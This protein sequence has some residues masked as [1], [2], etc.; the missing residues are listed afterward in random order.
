MKRMARVLAMLVL[1]AVA[2]AAS[3]SAA[4]LEDFNDYMNEDGTYSYYFMQGV[5]VTLSEEWYQN[6]FVK[7]DVSS[8]TFYHRD[9]YDKYAAEGMEDGGKLFTIGCSVNTSFKDLD[10][11]TYIGFDEEEMLNYYAVK[12]TDYTAY[13]SDAAT[14]AEYDALWAGVDEVIAGITLA[15]APKGSADEAGEVSIDRIPSSELYTIAGNELFSFEI[16]AGWKAWYN[17]ENT[18]LVEKESDE[19]AFIGVAAT[20][21]QGTVEDKL[22]EWKKECVEDFGER[23]AAEP[24]IITYEVEGTNRV[25]T[26]VRASISSEDGMDTFTCLDMIEELDGQYFHYGCSYLSGTYAEDKYEDETTYFE[27]LHAID[28]MEIGDHA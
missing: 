27:F 17:E 13:A 10:E 20:A 11:M 12:P 9:S 3:A 14:K 21:L 5:T 15:N 26:G 16:A 23:V 6:T 25:L 8:A 7:A 4:G 22:D 19:N 28:T 18:V 1:L 24:E 2:G